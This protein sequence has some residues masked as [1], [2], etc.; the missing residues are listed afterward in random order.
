MVKL[1]SDSEFSLTISNE[2][3]WQIVE[4]SKKKGMPRSVAK[5]L[6]KEYHCKNKDSRKH[7]IIV[8]A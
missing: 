5:I 3:R 1:N 6:K 8:K 7:F 4:I 2:E